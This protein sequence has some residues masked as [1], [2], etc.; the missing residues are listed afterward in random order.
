MRN[1]ALRILSVILAVAI[2]AV[3]CLTCAFAIDLTQT[4]SIT[5]K[6]VYNG[7]AVTGGV[8]TVYKVADLSADGGYTY[9]SD[10]A[11]YGGS[12][13]DLEDSTLPW[14]LWSWAK[15]TGAAGTSCT[16]GSDGIVT[17]S[18]LEAGVYLVVP[19]T[20]PTNFDVE[21]SIVPIPYYDT[22]SS[23]VYDVEIEAKLEPVT[24]PTTPPDTPVT[25]TTPSVPE[26]EIT[27]DGENEEP[28]DVDVELDETEPE[29]NEPE[30]QEEEKLPQT[31]QL[32]YPIPI[33]AG[34]GAICVAAGLIVAKT[35]KKK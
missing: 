3:S 19:S 32:N 21:P 18:G 17:F 29:N 4:G 34:A 26:E 28:G 25:T 31:G 35:D 8:L 30:E 7:N 2:A 15:Q 22:D 9:T 20:N 24:T 6:L 1:K 5:I 11:G 12:L 27:T 10:F 13:D 23:W 14:L 33:M 16:I